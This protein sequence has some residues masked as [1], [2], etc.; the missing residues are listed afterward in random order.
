MVCSTILGI[1]DVIG[2]GR[3]CI[4]R[5]LIP[6][7]EKV[8]PKESFSLRTTTIVCCILFGKHDG[9]ESKTQTYLKVHVPRSAHRPQALHPEPCIT[10]N[11][12]TCSGFKQLGFRRFSSKSRVG[13][14][15]VSHQ[16]GPTQGSSNPWKFE[17]ETLPE[18]SAQF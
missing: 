9:P 14:G 10:L 3:I 5:A 16:R 12:R 7:P 1:V 8:G 17:Q 4:R 15:D 11:F 13:P 2:G 6:E 18:G